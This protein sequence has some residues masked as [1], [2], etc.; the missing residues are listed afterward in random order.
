MSEAER[1][2]RQNYKRNRKRLIVGQA[3]SILLILVISLASFLVYN[4]MNKTYY[5]EYTESSNTDYAVKYKDN[6]FFEEGWMESGKSYVS[7]LVSTI[8]GDFNYKMQMDTSDVGFDYTYKVTA[9]TVVADKKTGTPIFN[10]VDV[11]VPE[12]KSHVSGSDGFAVKETVMVDFVKY[13][14]LA[15]NFV[16]VYGLS[17]TESTLVV[18]FSVDVISTC[19]EFESN[20]TNNHSV[21]LN[22]PLRE[23]NFSIETFSSVPQTESKVLACKSGFGQKLFL[24]LGTGS[25]ILAL[26]FA[27]ILV[28]FIYFTKNEDINYANKVRR[29]LSSYRSFIQ[30]IDGDFE[31]A[32][33]QL[34]PIKTFTEL[35]CIRDT[36]Q[37]PILMSEN[38]DETK[39]QFLI[40]TN[41]KILYLY[42]LKVD[43]YDEIYGNPNEQDTGAETDKS[44]EE[45]DV[46][47]DTTNTAVAAA[48]YSVVEETPAP[49][50]ENDTIC[51]GN[52]A[53]E[54]EE[55]SAIE[56]DG[57]ADEAESEEELAVYDENNNKVLI[58]CSRSCL[59]NIIQSDN[60]E[61]KA[62]Y[63]ELKNY[64]LSYKGVKA[65]MSWRNETFNKGRNQLF[66]LKIR[67]K[68]ICL[69]CALNPEEFDEAKYFHKTVTAKAYERVP[70]LVK[71][72]SDRALARA[73]RLVDKVMADFEIQPNPKYVA[74]DYVSNHPYE[75]TQALVDKGLIKILV[76]DGY[77]AIDPYHIIK[78]EQEAKL[79]TVDDVSQNAECDEGENEELAV[80]DENNKILIKC[81][82]SCLANIIQSD[83][84]GAKAYYNELKNYILSYKG[85]KARMSWRHESF[86]MGRNQLFKLKIRGKTICLYCAL[87][88]EE[89][90]EAKYFHKTV[91]AK[92]Y[93]RVPMLVKIRSDRALARAKRLVDK[94][95]ANFEIQPNPKYVAVDYVSKHPNE[96]TKVLIEK[97]LIKI[98]VPDEKK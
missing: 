39:S 95:T 88:P 93:E 54:A 23:E 1:K 47:G 58:K 24:T 84:K 17:N 75:R 32:G 63:S 15:D 45:N 49:V 41:T 6:T 82:R 5:I 12:T 69:Y 76:P 16:N 20:G 26:I 25:A 33:Y 29:I 55:A 10:P 71:I 96:R 53:P 91:T 94:V 43:N 57:D 73:K 7:S 34:V 27:I 80:Y 67:G 92:A 68:T 3:V 31:T 42:E 19:D 38:E 14:T 48:S 98:L 90:D 83:N 13:N 11:L 72:R 22:V 4:G 21:S 51:T 35:L 28:A 74:E 86:N 60:N 36:I 52:E 2:R 79:D 9:Q 56:K 50:S 66:K 89:F 40:P 30:Q 44:E 81:S 85:I 46:S 65:R 78:A 61:A 77:V 97:G 70:M 87:N 62:Y 18:T 64:I 37:S 8:R 59:A